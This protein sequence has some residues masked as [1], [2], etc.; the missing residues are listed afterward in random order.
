MSEIIP[1]ERILK[2][3]RKGLVV[4]SPNPFPVLDFDSPI[5]NEKLLNNEDSLISTFVNIPNTFF[6]HCSNKYDFLLSFNELSKQKAWKSIVCHSTNLTELFEDN[7]FQVH[8]NS[9]TA[10]SPLVTTCNKLFNN[11]ASLIFDM[12]HQYIKKI[13]MA[14][15]LVIVASESQIVNYQADKRFFELPVLEN[16]S[17][18]ILSPRMLVN[19]E[20]Y[21]FL[22]NDLI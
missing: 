3:V 21:L 16:H 14:P 12:R 19:H 10:N 17:K 4:P 5:Y 13:L 15:V 7:G 22:L 6:K 9:P 20:T 11:P 8:L 2:S 18:C 1:K